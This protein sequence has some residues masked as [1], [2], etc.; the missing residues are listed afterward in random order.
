MHGSHQNN[1]RI[2]T[3]LNT[4]GYELFAVCLI[5]LSGL[6]EVEMVQVL[7][8][9]GASKRNP[10]FR[11]SLDEFIERTSGLRPDKRGRLRSFVSRQ[12]RNEQQL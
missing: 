10:A 4:W 12:I 11:D 8:N 9:R 1:I 2:C 5:L 7:T 6:T 3:L